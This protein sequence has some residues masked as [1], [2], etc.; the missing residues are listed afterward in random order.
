[1]NLFS[2]VKDPDKIL[3]IEKLIMVQPDIN[4]D[5]PAPRKKR[6]SILNQITEIAINVRIVS[7]RV[8]DDRIH[9]WR[10]EAITISYFV[11]DS[12]RNLNILTRRNSF[13]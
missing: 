13:L 7:G 10:I 11:N 4:V 2:W 8:Y 1:M 3:R 6:R 9:N 12:M 5:V